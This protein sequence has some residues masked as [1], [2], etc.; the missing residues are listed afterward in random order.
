MTSGADQVKPI[1]TSSRRGMVSV[2]L[3]TSKRDEAFWQKQEKR[4][5]GRLGQPC[6]TQSKMSWAL[7]HMPGNFALVIHG[8]EDCLNCFHHHTGQSAG[9]VY[10]TRLTEYQITSG[11]TQRPLKH[12]LHLIADQKQPDAI[13]VLGTCPVEVIG[14]R[15]E[16]V[17]DQVSE[18]T[19]IPMTAL[20]TSGLKLTRL[21]DMQDWLYATL[22]TL[23]SG[24]QQQVAG[25]IN[26]IGLQDGVAN[27]PEL[28][29]MVKDLGLTIGGIYPNGTS[30]SD[31]QRIG[32]A[33]KSF[34]VDAS[35]FPRLTAHLESL[36]QEV[37][38]V[39]LPIGLQ[40]SRRFYEIMGTAVGKGEEVAILLE[41]RSREASAEIDA[42]RKELNGFPMA[43]AI[44]MLN[45]Y[46]SDQLAY[47]GLGD[48]ALLKECGLRVAL[49]VQ[50]PPE[51]KPA[52]VET[53]QE[54][55][56][57]QDPVEVFPGP[58]LLGERLREFGYRHAIA[59]DSCTATLRQSGVAAIPSRTFP[60]F[61][62]GV[63][64]GVALIR[65]LLV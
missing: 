63:S 7:I 26:I 17:V 33:E 11:E 57:I 54:R 19:G 48:F 29:E 14:D 52:F 58:W 6:C 45:T 21:V 3:E 10:S 9:N 24:S 43:M 40:Q 27:H 55:Y 51:E 1:Q 59:P 39:P 16:I 18:A 12:L 2:S 64:A 62:A 28:R 15:F 20:H 30:F 36:G 37:L 60:P 65:R 22:A 42:I 23:A 8:E 4:R 34:V 31:W 5:Q 32:E 38:E 35:A 44:R 41:E 46:R 47:D 56:G 61:F 49:F 25:T 50:G 13:I 53:L